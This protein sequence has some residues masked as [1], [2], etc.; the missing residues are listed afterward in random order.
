MKTLRGIT[1]PG[2]LRLVV[3][4][5]AKKRENSS[6]ARRYDQIRFRF[7]TA[8]VNS[9]RRASW[10]AWKNLLRYRTRAQARFLGSGEV[11]R[12]PN[13]TPSGGSFG[14]Y[15]APDPNSRLSTDAPGMRCRLSPS[16]DM[17][18][19]GP[20]PRWARARLPRCKKRLGDL[21]LRVNTRP[22]FHA[23]P[24]AIG[25]PQCGLRGKWMRRRELASI[26]DAGG[27]H[28]PAVATFRAPYRECNVRHG[29]RAPGKPAEG[30][31]R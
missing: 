9:R 3:T 30:R 20:G 28:H 10:P 18:P 27:P 8:W 21:G 5:R 25:C 22:G 24:T 31:R 29:H 12:L 6:S 14:R 4:L 17:P 11:G 1:A 13:G 26:P 7:H 2:I 16:A 19:L 23:A 15:G